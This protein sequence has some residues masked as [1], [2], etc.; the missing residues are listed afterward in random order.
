MLWVL[1][2][3]Y[4][5]FLCDIERRKTLLFKFKWNFSRPWYI[6]SWHSFHF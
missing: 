6:I 3:K 4:D 2:W 1:L 5:I